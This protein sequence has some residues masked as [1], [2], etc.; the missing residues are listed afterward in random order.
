[1]LHLF[2][3]VGAEKHPENAEQIHFN[4]EAE[5]Q[6]EQNQI[7]GERRIDAGRKVARENILNGAARSHHTKNFTE[8]P[9]EHPA[10]Q[11]EHQ[12]NARGFSHQVLPYGPA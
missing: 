5:C 7:Y 6:L 12:Q 1:M 11:D 10:D 4:A 2:V 9:A 3:Q 8:N